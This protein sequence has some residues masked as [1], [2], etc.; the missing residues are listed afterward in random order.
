V[1][2]TPLKRKTPLKAASG[3]LEARKPLPRGKGLA[4]R[5][6]RR[7]REYA[8]PGGRRDL[9]RAMLT[10]FPVCQVRWACRGARA[11]DVHERLT[12]AR[13]G[14]ILDPVQAH[15]V[16][17]CRACHD[18]IGREVAAATARRMLLPSWHRCPPVGPC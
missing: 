9:V 4:P 6:A 11:V 5:S 3:P 13:G 18:L 17:A 14:S 10:E 8:E 15:M 12:R 1:K 7:T 16:T 2:R